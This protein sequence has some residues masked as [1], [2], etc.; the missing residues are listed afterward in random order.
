[1]VTEKNGTLHTEFFVSICRTTS[2]IPALRPAGTETQA[3]FAS[4]R[5]Q[6]RAAYLHRRARFTPACWDCAMATQ[7]SDARTSPF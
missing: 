5:R 3:A 2:L 1:M 7:F 6:Q 4:E